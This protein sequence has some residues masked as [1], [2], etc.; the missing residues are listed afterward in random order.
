MHLGSEGLLFDMH[1]NLVE[2]IEGVEHFVESTKGH[3]F[4][5][6]H[7]CVLRLF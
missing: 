6:F 2:V 5:F 3:G 1:I 7:T 4:V